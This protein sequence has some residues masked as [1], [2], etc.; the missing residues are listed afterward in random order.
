MPNPI[1]KLAPK[2][3]FAILSSGLSAIAALTFVPNNAFAGCA[4]ATLSGEGKCENLSI[5][6]DASGCNDKGIGAPEKTCSGD[7][8]KFIFRGEKNL[9][10]IKLEK[11]SNTDNWGGEAW[12]IGSISTKSRI[13]DVSTPS[14]ARAEVKPSIT[15]P[16]PTPPTVVPAPAAK[17]EV[18]KTEVTQVVAAPV[19]PAPA[20][21]EKISREP[22]GI[23]LKLPAPEVATPA[24]ATSSPATPA[25]AAPEPQKGWSL[26]AFFDAYYLY[27]FGQPVAPVGLSNLSVDAAA[28]RPAQNTYRFYDEF[29]RQFEINLVE[30]ELK[31]VRKEVTFL[32][33][34]DFGNMADLNAGTATSSG[35]VV[36][37]VSKHIGQA[38]V[39]YS[40]DGAPGLLIEV[41]KMP[42]AGGRLHTCIRSS[43]RRMYLF[44]QILLNSNTISIL[45]PDLGVV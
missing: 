9:Y 11:S 21:A 37:E 12:K 29:H 31:H 34:L 42:M 35:Y 41:G 5:T 1:T 24:A 26:N 28:L 22:A 7:Q 18:P 43:R 27:N 15:P 8:P 25:A 13:R 19:P 32:A 33:D 6:L 36:D 30:F 38:M 39:S 23:P 20:A 3:L 17:A 4:K 44:Y 2:F 10:T 16:A 45:I 40:P 14:V